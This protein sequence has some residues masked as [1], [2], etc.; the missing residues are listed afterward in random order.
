VT[1]L[2]LTT[3]EQPDAVRFAVTSLATSRPVAGASVK[4]EGT[5]ENEWVTLAEGTT[6]ADGSFR[7]LAPG[8]DPAHPIYRQ[9][10]RLVVASADDVLVLDPLHAPDGYADNHWSAPRATWPQCAFRPLVACTPPPAAR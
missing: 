6:G 8:W 7:W 9:L 2:S 3:L 4:L 5:R 1:D 10:R